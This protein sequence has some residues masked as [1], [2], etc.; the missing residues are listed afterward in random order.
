MKNLLVVL[1][2]LSF[3]KFAFGET[4]EFGKIVDSFQKEKNFN[5]VVIVATDGKIDFISGV[6]ISDRQS[7]KLITNNSKFRIA[8]ITKTFTAVLILKLY[9][10]GKI[11]LNATIGKYFPT[12]KGIGK[13]K[14]TIHQLLTYS[15][16][17]PNEGEKGGML[18]YKSPLTLDEFISKYCSGSLEF[19]AG[20][21]SVY[22]NTE[23]IILGKIIENVT[24][25]SFEKVLQKEILSPL[26]LK[27]SGMA[28]SKKN[29]LNLVQSYTQND[30]NKSFE[31]DQP[32]LIENYFASGSMYSTAEDLLKFDNAIFNSKLL[33]P[34]TT[35]MM[36]KIYPN[37]GD[38]AYGFWGSDGFGNFAEKFY[39]RPGGIL[40]ST[41][42]WIHTMKNKKT[43]IVLSNTNVTNLFELSEKLYLAS[44]GKK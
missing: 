19:E 42:N 13:D 44:I 26:K 27:K 16:G 2:I 20:S 24:G 38:V 41:A 32:F 9:E 18:P 11:D 8:S 3:A 36:L 29:V 10:Q 35:E 30:A 6:G 37:L 28:N 4:S 40:G 39:Y 7:G 22:A 31:A 5:G 33:Q 43:V 23:Y 12:Y 25:K 21:K 1:L 34:K 15:S 17:I 14:V